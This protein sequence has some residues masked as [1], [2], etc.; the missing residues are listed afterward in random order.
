MFYLRLSSSPGLGLLAIR[1]NEPLRPR[2]PSYHQLAASL[3]TAPI[4]FVCRLTRVSRSRR[5]TGCAGLS[6]SPINPPDL[7]S[8]GDSRPPSSSPS[9]AS[10]SLAFS[11][12]IRADTRIRQAWSLF[13]SADIVLVSVACGRKFRFETRLQSFSSSHIALN[14]EYAGEAGVLHR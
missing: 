9:S 2:S 4:P 1:K 11:S 5:R 8:P 12:P 10:S 6:I 13:L 3:T 14:G 7:A